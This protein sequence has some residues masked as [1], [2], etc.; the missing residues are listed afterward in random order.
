MA[1]DHPQF[2][3]EGVGLV[4]RANQKYLDQQLVTNR[5]A[6]TKELFAIGQYL[7]T[8]GGT[9]FGRIDTVAK[10]ALG[11]DGVRPGIFHAPAR[12]R[13]AQKM[14]THD[15][16]SRT[17]LPAAGGEQPAQNQHR[18]RASARE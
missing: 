14:S 18:G 8:G 10:A 3:A 2:T 5:A 6:L 13:L 12:G 16:I 1:L 4:N 9:G 11:P 17:R 15:A 7:Y